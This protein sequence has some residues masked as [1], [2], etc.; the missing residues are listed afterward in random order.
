MYLL[1]R[2]VNDMVV[3]QTKFKIGLEA[4]QDVVGDIGDGPYVQIVRVRSLGRLPRISQ[5]LVANMRAESA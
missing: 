3:V 1:T 2:Y 5:G 4:I